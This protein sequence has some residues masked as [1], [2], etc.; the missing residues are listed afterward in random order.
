MIRRILVYTYGDQSHENTLN[1]AAAYAAKN[2]AQLTGLFVK[3]DYINYSNFYG[4]YPLNLAKT[5]Y[6][7]QDSYSEDN[8]LVFERALKQYG[9]EGEWHVVDQYEPTPRPELYTDC[10]LVGQPDPKS[11]VIF[12]ETDFIDQLI[13]STGV[14]V[15][16][17][18]KSWAVTDFANRPLLGWKESKEAAG[19]VR[20]A[21]SVM[22]KAEEVHILTVTKKVTPEEE[23]ICGIQISEYLS[24]HSIK[25]RFYE[26][27]MRDIDKTG[28]DAIVRHVEEHKRDL[29]I[30]GGYSHSRFREIVL[31]GV[32]RE[33]VKNSPVPL[34]LAH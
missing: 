10:I 14:P 28:A 8:R 7:R 19:A 34:M 18:P 25:C 15:I 11:S 16:V 3:P 21:M 32:T 20:Q 24:A 4:Q 12:S 13:M 23:L 9:C 31:G 30:I 22:Q 26:E 17:I 5:F 1:A 2:K 6:D 27:R 29:I 33:L